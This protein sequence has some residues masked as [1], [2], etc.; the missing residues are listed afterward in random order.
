[1]SISVWSKGEKLLFWE[2]TQ[3]KLC[4]IAVVYHAEKSDGRAQDAKGS[5]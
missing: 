2:K 5:F 1:M 3:N 4:Y